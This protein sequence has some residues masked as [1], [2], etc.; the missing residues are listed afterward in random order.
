VDIAPGETLVAL[1]GAANRDP[2]KFVDP[3]VFQLERP[4]GADHVDFGRGITYC[5]GAPFAMVEGEVAFETLI[6]RLGRFSLAVDKTQLEWRPTIWARGV[7]R[8]PIR[9]ELG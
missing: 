9:C 6:S 7:Q 5:L 1:F 4:Y 8:L 2:R 3:N